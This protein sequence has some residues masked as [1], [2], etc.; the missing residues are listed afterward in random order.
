MKIFQATV[1]ESCLLSAMDIPGYSHCGQASKRHVSYYPFE[2]DQ[3][4]VY[5]TAPHRTAAAKQLTRANCGGRDLAEFS[6]P[7]PESQ[8]AAK[9]KL[10]SEICKRETFLGDFSRFEFFKRLFV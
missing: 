8:V 1:L 3:R 7:S 2:A 5:F 4:I 10:A 6:R 9:R